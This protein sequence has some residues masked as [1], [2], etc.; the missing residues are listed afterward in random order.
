MN[1]GIE[2][3]RRLDAGRDQQPPAGFGKAGD[4]S[5]EYEPKP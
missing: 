2:K 5:E 1:R 4:E 3:Q